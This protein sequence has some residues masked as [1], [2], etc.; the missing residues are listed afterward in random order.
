MVVDRCKCALR[1]ID[2][3]SMK[4]LPSISTSPCPQSVLALDVK[5][6]VW[7]LTED[8]ILSVIDVNRSLAFSK[9]TPKN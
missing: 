2:I 4:P 8:F 5:G 1:Q 9:D 6:G 7:C 3:T